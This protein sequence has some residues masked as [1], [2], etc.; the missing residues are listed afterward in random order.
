MAL[1]IYPL[2]NSLHW[3]FTIHIGTD[4]LYVEFMEAYIYLLQQFQ[5]Q[6]SHICFYPKQCGMLLSHI[7]ILLLWK[8]YNKS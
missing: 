8:M 5:V 1:F 4:S 2:P 6:V 7:V 3:G